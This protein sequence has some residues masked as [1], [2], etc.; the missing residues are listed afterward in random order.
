MFDPLAVDPLEEA[1]WRPKRDAWFP[2]DV[3][4]D[5]LFEEH[6]RWV[7]VRQNGERTRRA[8]P[9]ERSRDGFVRVRVVEF[10]HAVGDGTFAWR[11]RAFPKPQQGT[12]LVVGPRVEYKPYEGA[13][14]WTDWDVAHGVAMMVGG[15]ALHLVDASL[16]ASPWQDP[17]EQYAECETCGAPAQPGSVLHRCTANEAHLVFHD[18][19]TTRMKDYEAAKRERQEAFQRAR[20]LLV[21]AP[22]L[23][24]NVEASVFE[25]AG[26][27]HAAALR[28]REASK[29]RVPRDATWQ[30]VASEL[31]AAV[32]RA[33]TA[34]ESMME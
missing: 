29:T 31:E 21:V 22:W 28:V 10:L 18:E 20:R 11:E 26:M 14:V 13:F 25:A 2:S 4:R 30:R 1:M 7:V 34:L 16:F 27:L 8:R 15:Y 12:S 33:K 32:A 23:R 24:E 9:D 17:S 6:K 19:P 3:P 5:V